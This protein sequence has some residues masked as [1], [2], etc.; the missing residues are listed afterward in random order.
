VGSDSRLV[1][2][3][4]GVTRLGNINPRLYELGNLQSPTSGLHDITS[5]NND[6]GAILGYG[7][8]LGYDQV[9]GW[10]TPN[11]ALLVAAFP[12]AALS[13][14]ETSLKLAMGAS[15]ETGAFSLA[16]TTT[17]PLQLNSFILGVTSPKLLASV[18]VIAT[19][20]G[21]TQKVTG[22]PARRTAFLFPSPLVIP[23]SQTAEITLNITAAKKRGSSFL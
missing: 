17:D 4:Q 16:N 18:Q 7:A 5:G 6:D 10:G 1:A 19:V 3:S 13:T 22:T 20:G 2:Q 14:K 23:S 15:A 11:I 21:V 9:T 8:A 12:G